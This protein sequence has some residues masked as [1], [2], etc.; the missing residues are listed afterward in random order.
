MVRK[1]EKWN[2]TVSRK[3]ERKEQGEREGERMGMRERERERDSV[4]EEE[5][6]SL[7]SL[8]NGYIMIYTDPWH[9]FPS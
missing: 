7:L 5:V 3:R 4:I 1:E 8:C 9:T 6:M 2:N